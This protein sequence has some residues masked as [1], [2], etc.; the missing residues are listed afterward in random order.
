MESTWMTEIIK[1]H[2]AELN[3]V[4][5]VEEEDLEYRANNLTAQINRTSRARR[6]FKREPEKKGG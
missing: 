2:L 1:K 6:D 5:P 4:A 3:A